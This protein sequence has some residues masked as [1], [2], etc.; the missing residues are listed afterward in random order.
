[1]RIHKFIKAEVEFY[2]DEC[3]FVNDEIDVY[4]MRSKGVSLEKI[5]EIKQFSVDGI[6]KISSDVDDKINRVKRHYGIS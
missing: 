3:N 1:M 4:E 6:K 5:A 2:R